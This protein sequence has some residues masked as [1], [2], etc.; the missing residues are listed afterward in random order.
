MYY[1]I[2][3][4]NIDG[5]I[6]SEQEKKKFKN[7][8]F[9]KTTYEDYANLIKQNQNKEL[10][11]CVKSKSIVARDKPKGI[12]VIWD[13][14]N[15]VE[16]ASLEQQIEYYKNL[17]IQKTIE[18]G[19][20]NLAGFGNLNLESELNELKKIHLEKSHKLALQIENKLKEL[21]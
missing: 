17:I 20:E 4:N 10:V 5:I 12:N 13:G 6:Y 15:F 21:I 11:Y 3:N 19:I 18:L 9:I 14:E 8:E 7:A 2:L 1:V 16:T